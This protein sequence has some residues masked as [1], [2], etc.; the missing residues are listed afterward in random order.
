MVCWRS[1][2]CVAHMLLDHMRL[3]A[4]PKDSAAAVSFTAALAEFAASLSFF[5]IISCGMERGSCAGTIAARWFATFAFG[6]RVLVFAFAVCHLGGGG[7]NDAMAWSLVALWG[8]T[9][10][11]GRD[12]EP[13]LR[14]GFRAKSV[15]FGQ[16]FCQTGGLGS[17]GDCWGRLSQPHGCGV[18]LRGEEL[19]RLVGG[20]PRA[21]FLNLRTVLCGNAS[22][23]G[24]GRP[25]RLGSCG[26]CVGLVALA[27]SPSSGFCLRIG[28]PRGALVSR[29][30]CAP[31]DARALARRA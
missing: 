30:P 16:R 12:G 7:N 20:L 24:A 6:M 25:G 9:L 1:R 29:P 19:D 21:S 27:L 23:P 2:M 17:R 31:V 28:G 18:A 10:R 22:W 4:K 13:R 3:T 5:I 26:A 8:A 15:R 14:C 11:Q